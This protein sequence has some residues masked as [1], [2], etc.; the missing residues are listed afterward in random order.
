MLLL[1]QNTLFFQENLCH[2]RNS[3][4]P[5]IILHS[6]KFNLW[7][8]FLLWNVNFIITFLFK[9][10]IPW[11]LSMVWLLL[12]QWHL[13]EIRFNQLSIFFPVYKWFL[14]GHHDIIEKLKAR[15]ISI[16][17]QLSPP[18]ILE[19]ALLLLLSGEVL[20]WKGHSQGVSAWRC[21]LI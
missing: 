16:N 15:V 8:F 5:W 12:L 14:K 19:A 18:S 17:I 20:I 11:T 1:R 2:A 9:Q 6:D 7:L 3:L 10:L 13:G 4:Y 21:N